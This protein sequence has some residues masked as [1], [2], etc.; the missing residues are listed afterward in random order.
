MSDNKGSAL[1]GVQDNAYPWLTLEFCGKTPEKSA[2][3]PAEGVQ[4]RKAYRRQLNMCIPL[5]DL[6]FSPELFSQ[7]SV[8]RHY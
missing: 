6:K 4:A 2:K 8:D 7:R 5:F 1:P 3:G